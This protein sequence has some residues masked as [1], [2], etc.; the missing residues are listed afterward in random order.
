MKHKIWWVQVIGLRLFM[1][2]DPDVAKCCETDRIIKPHQRDRIERVVRA[3][4]AQG[5][6]EIDDCPPEWE[7]FCWNNMGAVLYEPPNWPPAAKAAKA[8]TPEGAA[9]RE[10]VPGV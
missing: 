7:Q 6:G 8:A 1:Q 5:I 4:V 2:R 3:L 10:S 9:G